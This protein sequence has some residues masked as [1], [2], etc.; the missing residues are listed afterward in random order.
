MTYVRAGDLVLSFCDTKIKAVGVATGLA[1]TETRPEFGPTGNQWNKQGWRVPVKFSKIADPIKPKDLIDD[2]RSLLPEQYS[3]LQLNGDGNQGVYLAE[4]SKELVLVILKKM[5]LEIND[6][7]DTSSINGAGNDGLNTKRNHFL[8]TW[9][10][11]HWGID[12]IEGLL[13]LFDSG[14]QTQEDWRMNSAKK[15]KLGDVVW[16]MQQGGDYRIFA[17]GTV[18]GPVCDVLVQGKERPGFPILFD[19]FVDPRTEYLVSSE[20]V[21]QI[22]DRN[23]WAAQASGNAIRLDQAVKLEELIGHEAKAENDFLSAIKRT[24]QSALDT[25]YAS[26]GPAK[27]QVP[28]AKTFGFPSRLAFEQYLEALMVKQKNICKLTGLKICPEDHEN[29]D[30][31]ASLDRIDSSLGY[32]PG[33]LQYVCWFANRW[34]RDNDN[35]EFLNLLELIKAVSPHRERV[36]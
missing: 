10:A 25:V 1:E 29:H 30:L 33:N 12:K 22:L 28:K 15:A 23:Q 7:V 14:A 17:K 32:E 8:L 18:N 4:V 31:R 5:A 34:K 6:F 20:H 11:E 3:P 9:K 19:Q 16:V 24:S 27:L 26:G 21:L 35:A 36:L 13:Q 2:L